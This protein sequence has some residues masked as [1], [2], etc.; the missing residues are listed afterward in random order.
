MSVQKRN[1]DGRI[2]K[3]GTTDQQFNQPKND[4]QLLLLRVFKSNLNLENTKRGRKKEISFQHEHSAKRIGVTEKN[5]CHCF[6]V[7]L[8]IASRLVTNLC[9]NDF[10]ENKIAN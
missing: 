3:K 9:I 10:Q 5:A 1:K 4:A 8:V 6:F 7:F 2:E